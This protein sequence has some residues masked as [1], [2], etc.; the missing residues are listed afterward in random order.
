MQGGTG[1]GPDIVTEHSGVP[2]I[3]AIVEADEALKHINLR[4]KVNLV[5]GGGIRN[6]A[7]VAKAIALGADAVY[8]ATAA[9]VSIGCRV[10]QMCYAGTCR[11]GIAT[12]NP[13]L[14][15]RLD[16]IEGGKRVARYIEAMTEEAVMLTQQAGN[17]DIL[18]LE[19]DDLRALTVESSVLTG[20]KMAGLEA[21]MNT[22]K[23]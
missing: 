4:E 14:R 3:A 6:G 17:T 13:Q 12:Q 1:A 16:Y 5:A 11:K 18:K 19:K 2:T 22:N 20:V 9:L 23:P 21:P 8:I 15:R 10:C 7:D